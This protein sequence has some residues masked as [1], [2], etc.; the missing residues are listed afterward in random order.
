M[1]TLEYL[2]KNYQCEAFTQFWHDNILLRY[3]PSKPPSRYIYVELNNRQSKLI[4]EIQGDLSDRII[5]TLLRT[6]ILSECEK[7]YFNK[8]IKSYVTAYSFVIRSKEGITETSIDNFKQ[9]IML[10]VLNILKRIWIYDAI[11]LL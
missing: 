2:L 5:G 4:L 7:I 6:G 9:Y 11:L 1:L 10:N 8:K 3:N